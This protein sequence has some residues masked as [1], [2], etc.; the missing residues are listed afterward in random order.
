M[1]PHRLATRY[2]RFND[3]RWPALR[4]SMKSTLTSMGREGGFRPERVAFGQSADPARHS[5]SARVWR[6]AL[7]NWPEPGRKHHEP[8]SYL[9]LPRPV[10]LIWGSPGPGATARVG[11]SFPRFG[12]RTENNGTTRRQCLGLYSARHR[13]R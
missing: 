7:T 5:S 8:L 2:A 13:C 4:S 11:E 10:Q 6:G 1:P 12:T 9:N 3:A